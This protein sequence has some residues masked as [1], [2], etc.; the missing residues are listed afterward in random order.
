MAKGRQI[1]R[2]T[3]ANMTHSAKILA[4]NRKQLSRK[5]MLDWLYFGNFDL[6]SKQVEMAS[7]WLKSFGD[8][9]ARIEMD[10]NRSK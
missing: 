10:Q 2:V 4:V 5:V 8:F 9:D 7:M 6:V 3:S 1:S